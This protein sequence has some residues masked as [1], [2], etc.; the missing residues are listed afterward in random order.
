MHGFEKLIAPKGFGGMSLNGRDLVPDENGHVWVLPT[1]LGACLSHGFKRH[2]G[3]D[4]LSALADMKYADLYAEVLKRTIAVLQGLSAEDLR[5]RLQA[6]SP[7]DLSITG[8]FLTP[9]EPDAPEEVENTLFDPGA[10]TDADVD[11]MPFVELKKFLKATGFKVLPSLKQ[12][13]LR[14]AAHKFF[15][16][17]EAAKATEFAADDKIVADAE[18][19]FE[20]APEFP[21]AKE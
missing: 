8:E 13:E 17:R 19:E 20:A 7:P 12:V 3:L 2:A 21:F 16:D 4:G 11:A 6:S 5:A 18:Y 10:L 1:E 14:E 15:T 9:V